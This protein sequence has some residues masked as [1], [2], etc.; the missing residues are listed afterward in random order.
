MGQRENK[1][2]GQG[3]NGTKK[4]VKQDNKIWGQR[5]TST[6]RQLG[7]L[8]SRTTQQRNKETNK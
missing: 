3:N 6:I 8:D 7:H 1:I 5:K 4:K 2:T